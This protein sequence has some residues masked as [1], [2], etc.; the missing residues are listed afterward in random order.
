MLSMF[1]E[2][3]YIEVTGMRLKGKIKDLWKLH[4]QFFDLGDLKSP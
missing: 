4:S 3:E 2:L 1:F